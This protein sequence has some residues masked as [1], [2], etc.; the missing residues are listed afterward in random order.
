MPVPLPFAWARG[1][2]LRAP[3]HAIPFRAPGPLTGPKVFQIQGAASDPGRDGV[4]SVMG[5]PGWS[6]AR[7]AVNQSEFR[8]RPA[9]GTSPVLKGEQRVGILPPAPWGGRSD[10]S[11]HMEGDNMQPTRPNSIPTRLQCKTETFAKR[12]FDPLR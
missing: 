3:G 2:K 8:R 10:R 1:R 7:C 6:S 4:R 5:L 12:S 11:G 9:Q